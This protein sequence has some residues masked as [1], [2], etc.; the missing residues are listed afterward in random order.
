MF[1]AKNP[2]QHCHSY[3]P[4]NSVRGGSGLPGTTYPPAETS[5]RTSRLDR[6]KHQR[7]SGSRDGVALVN[8]FCRAG[9]TGRPG[10]GL[11]WLP[12]VSQDQEW[13]LIGARKYLH[14]CWIMRSSPRLTDVGWLR[15]KSWWIFSWTLFS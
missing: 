9:G 7:P 12:G 4:G 15:S 10:F 8:N 1:Q 5:A 3:C 11:C 2:R 14:C 13:S 6:S